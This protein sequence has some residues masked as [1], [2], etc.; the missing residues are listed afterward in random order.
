MK[1]LNDIAYLICF[2]HYLPITACEYTK[3]IPRLVY[4]ICAAC[5][6]LLAVIYVICML[7][8]SCALLDAV[9]T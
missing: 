7:L 8:L 9:R 1:S 3:H 4:V 5:K 6:S 2:R